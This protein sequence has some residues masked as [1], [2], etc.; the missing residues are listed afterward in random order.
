[1]H[2]PI[3]FLGLAN[4]LNV[5]YGVAIYLPFLSPFAVDKQ[6]LGALTVLGYFLNVFGAITSIPALL[7]GFAELYA[8]V[9][10]RGLYVTDQKTG[11]KTLEPVV[12]TTLTHVSFLFAQSVSCSSLTRKF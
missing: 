4:A 8:M 9:N 3:A 5:L 6:N 2:F 12:K 10:A 7:T 11:S 1:V